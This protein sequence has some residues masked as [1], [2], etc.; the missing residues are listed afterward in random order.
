LYNWGDKSTVETEIQTLESKKERKKKER[1]KR[2][3]NARLMRKKEN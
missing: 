1:K 3:G 2:E